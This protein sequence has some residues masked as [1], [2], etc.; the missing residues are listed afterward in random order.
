MS[1]GFAGHIGLAKE[2]VWGTAVAA[3]DFL[4]AY[5]ENLTLAIDR[6]DVKNIIG[7]R[8][9]MADDMSGILRAEGDI[10][11]PGHPIP[12]GFFLRS[13][14]GTMSGSTV[15]SGFL[16][17]NDFTFALTDFSTDSP[18]PPYTFEIFRDVTSAFQYTGGAV[19][20][21]TMAVQPNQDLRC[22]AHMVA[23]AV[24]VIAKSSPTF[25]TS[26][27]FPFAFDT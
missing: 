9:Y 11:F 15:L 20:R 23:R 8:M 17:Q 3:T 14:L 10:V 2:T 16:Y 24:S 27:T 12:L 13:V 21:F 19:S 6:F 26:P 18:I 4:E 5:S 7:G 25:P 1:Y 22:T